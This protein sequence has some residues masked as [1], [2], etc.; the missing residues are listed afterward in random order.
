MKTEDGSRNAR[1]QALLP[2]AMA[3][4]RYRTALVAWG[5]QLRERIDLPPSPILSGRLLRVVGLTMEAIG[6][7][8]EI[9]SWC[10]IIGQNGQRLDAEVIGFAGE[11]TFLMGSGLVQALRPGAA[12]RPMGRTFSVR[13]SDAWLGRVV[14]GWGQPVD[15][16]GPLVHHEDDT[17]IALETHHH[18]PLD[19]LSPSGALDVGV[20]AINGLLT[21]ARGQRM[22]IMAGTGVGKSVLL[23][24]MARYTAADRVVVALVGERGREVVEF[25]EQILGEAGMAKAVVVAAPADCPPLERFH[26]SLL[27][28]ALAEV[29]RDQGHDVLLLMDSLTRFAQAQREIGLAIGEP[30]VTRGYPPS[31]FSR[32]PHLVER[33]GRRHG[34]R[35]SITG[36]YTV[37]VEGDDF[38]DPIADATRAVVDGHIVL[39]RRLAEATHFPAIDVEASVNRVM[40]DAVDDAQWQSAQAFRRAYALYR[41]NEDLLM[42]GAYRRGANP[43][44]DRVVQAYP[45]MK[46]FLIQDGRVAVN[47]ADSKAAL[48]R[49]VTMAAGSSVGVGGHEQVA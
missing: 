6:L 37:L 2:E 41:Q 9:G 12:V 1:Q 20:R 33:A 46:D 25:V 18:S 5:R 13:V 24:M 3:I 47:L 23:G 44:L 34:S 15:H 38:Q 35:G 14:D 8:E 17:A 30:P 40:R 11:R 7:R 43:A 39:S 31:V 32:L 4:D 28:T 36:F 19:R 45:A 29:F 49:V 16:K 26:A 21:I 10:Q 22:A 42:V 27:A 48:R